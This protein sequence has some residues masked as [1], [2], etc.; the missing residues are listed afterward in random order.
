MLPYQSLDRQRLIVAS[1]NPG[2]VAEYRMLLE[3]AR[4]ELDGFDADVEET[5]DSYEA[6]AVLKARAACAAT[7]LPAIADDSGLEVEALDGEPGIHSRRLAPSQAERN[8]AL[9]DRLRDVPRPWRARFVCVIAL[10]TP[11]GEVETYRGEAEGE[12]LPEPRGEHGF[13]YD[14]IFLDTELGRTFAELGPEEK[15]RRSHRGRAF[16]AL[17]RSGSLPRLSSL[18]T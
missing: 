14:P 16:E 15:I 13:G 6:N 2:K 11:D 12:L 9:W 4:V 18:P 3:G 7:G 10:A 5:G 8:R 17:R 1:T